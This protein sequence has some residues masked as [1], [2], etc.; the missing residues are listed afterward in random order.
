[1]LMDNW[2][3]LPEGFDKKWVK[4]FVVA[5][6]MANLFVNIDMGILPAST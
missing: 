5:Q 3:H 4:Y 1:M 2:A 6:F